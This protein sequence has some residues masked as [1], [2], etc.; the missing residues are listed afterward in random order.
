VCALPMVQE[1]RQFSHQKLFQQMD[2][3]S[4]SRH[5]VSGPGSILGFALTL[6][7]HPP[8]SHLKS[9]M[10]SRF[11]SCI[12]QCN[13]N[14]LA[15]TQYGFIGSHGNELFE[16]L[17]HQCRKNATQKQ[18]TGLLTPALI[19]SRV[20]SSVIQRAQATAIRARVPKAE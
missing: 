9:K 20:V 11:C 14:S 15:A 16:A 8:L 19:A 4:L 13:K 17:A 1:A 3:S 7:V 2:R 10:S 6:L 5:L 18:S 12:S